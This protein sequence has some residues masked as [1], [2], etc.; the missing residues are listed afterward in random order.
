MHQDLLAIYQSYL[1]CLNA[2][3]WESVGTFVDAEVSR[4]GDALGLAG[5]R[6]MLIKDHEAIPDLR[7]VPV[8]TVCDQAALGA[9]LKF[10][11]NPIGKF[12]GL[13]INGRRVVFHENVFYEFRNSKIFRV[14]SVIDKA[15]I[16]QQLAA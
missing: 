15:A 8:F 4:N 10:D 3:D 14:R 7:F 1:A 5:Y 13:P 2:Q 6:D 11:C 12:M 16:E 9:V